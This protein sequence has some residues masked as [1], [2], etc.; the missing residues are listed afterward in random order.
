[1]P[2]DK[3]E[4]HEKIVK[5][6]LQ[7]FLTYG[8]KDASMRRIASESAM[9]AS[10]LYKHF[11][12]KEDMFSSLVEPAYSG[13]IEMYKTASDEARENLDSASIS[14]LFESSDEAV[15]LTE[16]IYDNFDAFKLIVC[17]AEGT[18]YENFSHDIAKLGE[19]STL[20]LMD[21]LKENGVPLKSYDLME[22]HLLTTTYIDALCQTVKHDF[23]REKAIHYAK[24]LDS[25]FNL[26]WKNFFGF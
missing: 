5:A 18:R 21:K 11:P 12:S 23:P 3:T 2:K 26:S 6:A 19:D 16:Y 1:M 24:T 8:F 20:Q 25:F 15:W 7:E 17:Y 14:T 10:G 22:F 4:N 13:L 9:S